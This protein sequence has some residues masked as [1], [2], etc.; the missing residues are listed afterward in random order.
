MPQ[1]AYDDLDL[2][3]TICARYAG[4]ARPESVRK[5]IDTFANKMA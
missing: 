1:S 4:R 3:K 5:T 2:S